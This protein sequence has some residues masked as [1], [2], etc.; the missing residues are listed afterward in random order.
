[1]A[2]AAVAGEATAEAVGT[3]EVEVRAVAAMARVMPPIRGRARRPSAKARAMG[4]WVLHTPRAA[5]VSCSW[6]RGQPG[7]ESRARRPAGA[8]ILLGRPHQ[9]SFCCFQRRESRPL[10]SA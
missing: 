6:C 1:M 9:V 3:V 8:N 7:A 5:R 2:V 10:Y 4:P